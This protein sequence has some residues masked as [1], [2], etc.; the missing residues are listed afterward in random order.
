MKKIF[1]IIHFS[2]CCLLMH[3]AQAQQDNYIIKGIILEVDSIPLRDASVRL[4][5]SNTQSISG[6]NGYFTIVS[7]FRNDTL[8]VKYVGYAEQRIPVNSN[9]LFP[10]IVRLTGK[11]QPLQEVVVETGYQS[12]PKERSTGSFTQI[13]NQLYNQQVGTSVLGRLDGITNG[14]TVDKKRASAYA[15]GIMVRGLSTIGGPK[16]PLIVL[17]NFPY[18]GDLNN[19]NPNDVESITIL[20]DAAAASIWGTR[21]GNGV[22]V[23]T[24]RKGHYNQ[25]VTIDLT[26]NISVTAKPD[27]WYTRPISS[28]DY[29]DV[30]Q[31]LYTKGFYNSSI[32]SIFKPSLSPVIELLIKKN[33]GQL[34]PAVADERINAL[35]NIDARTDFDKYVYRSS[36][37]KQ[38]ALTMRGGTNA[39]TW[40]LSG[41]YDH[42][43]SELSAKYQRITLHSENTFHLS[44]HFQVSAGLYFIQN[45][46]ESGQNGYGMITSGNGTSLYPYAM[47]G[48]NN[49]NA[50][51]VTR[52]YRQVYLDTVGRGKLLDWKY[53]PLDD[54]KHVMNTVKKYDLLASLKLNYRISKSW[55]AELQ[56]R[57]ENQ[58]TTGQILYDPQSFYARDIINSFTQLNYTTGQAT[59]KVP[60]GGILDNSN[61]LLEAHNSRAQLNYTNTW[62]QHQ[63]TGVAGADIRETKNSANAYRTYGYNNDILT[64]GNVDYTIT[65][66]VLVTGFPSFIPNAGSMGGNLNRFV[67]VYTNLAYTY[68]ERYTLSASGRRDASNLFGIKTNQKWTPLW[69]SGAAWHI[70]REPFYQLSWL[71]YLKF[72]LTYGYSGN[73]DPNQSAVTTIMYQST[74]PYTLT[75]YASI[76]RYPNPDLRGEKTSQLNARIDFKIKGNRISGSMEYFMKKGIDLYG[77]TPIDYTTGIGNTVLKNSASMKGNGFD[78][79]LNTINT[80]K[81]IKWL[82]TLLFNL[83]KDKV[84][85]YYTNIAKANSYIYGANVYTLSPLKGYPVYSVF[86]YRWAGLDAQTGN[87]MGYFNKQVSGNYNSIVTDSLQNAV[88]NGPAFPVTQIALRNTFSYGPFSFSLNIVGKFGYY[89][90]RSSIDYSGLFNNGIGGHADFA[91]RWQKPGDEVHTNVASMMYPLIGNRDVFYSGSEVLVEKGDHIRL[92]YITLSYECTKNQF[93][94]LPMQRLRVFANASNL[95]ILWRANSVQMDPDYLNNIIPPS[96]TIAIGCNISF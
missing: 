11:I 70:S 81:K 73:V 24:T 94:K 66:P 68:K 57:Y 82:T 71:P 64:Y 2:C 49:G 77:L 86:S 42:N 56:Y 84:T 7:R 26:S 91:L 60:K 83:Y 32:S 74:S 37:N 62:Q 54:Y 40:L 12:L 69:S 80:D 36:V 4:Q 65:H 67:S 29:I 47:L 43:L 50:L 13:N 45:N 75:P 46:N 14:L 63:L 1:L 96:A 10:I 25:P 53:Y 95:G 78:V 16:D 3:T 19:I 88:Y 18:D 22:I 93:K 58:R 72:S 5:L 8:L 9:T 31:F 85:D 76:N 28:S 23:I 92:Q 17:D 33:N 15:T 41:G 39:V 52:N 59:Y 21:A 38:Y 87:P 34:T 20:K 61:N 55:M 89:F 27:I 79:E 44:N 90:R 48:D 30:E 51:P 35:R 6:Q